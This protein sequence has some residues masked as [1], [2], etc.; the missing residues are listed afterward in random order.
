MN[1]NYLTSIHDLSLPQPNLCNPISNGPARSFSLFTTPPSAYPPTSNYPG[2]SFHLPP[3]SATT[4]VPSATSSCAPSSYRNSSLPPSTTP[5]FRHTTI[6]DN[7]TH[8]PADQNAT[9][10]AAKLA[11]SAIDPG[12]S[13][14]RN[15]FPCSFP[16]C[17]LS[18]ERRYNLKV[19]FRKHTNEKPY[20]CKVA[21]CSSAFKWR[22]SAKHHLLYHQRLDRKKRS[23]KITSAST[24]NGKMKEESVSLVLKEIDEVILNSRLEPARTNIANETNAML[25]PFPTMSS[26]SVEAD[27]TQIDATSTMRWPNPTE[28]TRFEMTFDNSFP[29]FTEFDELF[30]SSL[31]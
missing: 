8:L 22:S 3:F 20:K 6:Q 21:G 1:N 12:R 28:D 15:R 7:K 27:S 29:C 16:N 13:H 18:F 9:L 5:S 11:A 24:K 2:Y 19:H 4:S 10:L 23:N 31:I 30:F 25:P 17:S 14:G 26:S